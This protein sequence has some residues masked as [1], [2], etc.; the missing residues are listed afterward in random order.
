MKAVITAADLPDSPMAMPHVRLLDTAWR[1]RRRSRRPCV[2]AVAD[3]DARTARQALKLIEVDY[4]V[5]PH[6]TD[7]TRR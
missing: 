7:A 5:L 2:A 4:E 1:A 3:V 6:V